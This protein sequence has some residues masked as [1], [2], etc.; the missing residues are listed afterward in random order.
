MSALKRTNNQGLTQN[1][2]ELRDILN[3]H[4][5]SVGKKLA[6]DV[7]SSSQH[8]SDYFSDQVYPNSFF[9]DPVTSSEIES[10]LLSTPLNKAYGLYSCSIRI[11]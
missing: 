9:F 4:F 10:E 6:D 2:S 8:F 7:P 5:T 11:F 1:S 3:G